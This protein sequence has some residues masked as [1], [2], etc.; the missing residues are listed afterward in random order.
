MRNGR[1]DERGRMVVPSEVREEL[2]QRPAQTLRV[3]NGLVLSPATGADDSISRLKGCVGGSKVR[4][5]ELNW[6]GSR[7]HD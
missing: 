3:S 1:I 6:D 7:S 2:G 5:G 4:P